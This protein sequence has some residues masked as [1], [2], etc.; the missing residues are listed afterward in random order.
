MMKA[1]WDNLFYD[2]VDF[3][4]S[5]VDSEKLAEAY[6]EEIRHDLDQIEDAIRNYRP[7]KALSLIDECKKY[8]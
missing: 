4:V 8:Y 3:E 5:R 1:F 2:L 7:D 6:G